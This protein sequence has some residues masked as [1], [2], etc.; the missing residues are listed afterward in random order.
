[1]SSICA[2]IKLEKAENVMFKYQQ[3]KLLKS[4][5]TIKLLENHIKV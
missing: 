4:V 2:I 3:T 1:M 5:P